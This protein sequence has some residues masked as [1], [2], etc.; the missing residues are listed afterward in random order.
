MGTDDKKAKAPAGYMAPSPVSEAR[1]AAN[2]RWDRENMTTV[3]CRITKVKAFEFKMACLAL[4]TR[5]NQVFM[6]AI[7]E[8]IEEAKQKSR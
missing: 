1:K 4:G 6:K 3:G 5:P 2:A 8:T 7:A